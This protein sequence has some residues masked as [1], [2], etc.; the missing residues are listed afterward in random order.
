MLIKNQFHVA[1]V[2]FN[3]F[4]N[5]CFWEWLVNTYEFRDENS[6]ETVEEYVDQ[7]DYYISLIVDYEEEAYTAEEYEFLE[8]QEVTFVEL[9][10]N[11]QFLKALYEYISAWEDAELVE[12]LEKL[13]VAAAEKDKEPV[14]S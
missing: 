5:E 8:E 11:H 13:I 10:Y 6:E 14:A 7:L 2:L 1:E 9:K 12:G 3:H 4:R